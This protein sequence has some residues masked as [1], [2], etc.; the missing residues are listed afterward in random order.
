MIDELGS[1]SKN[2]IDKRFCTYFII[3]IIKLCGS[4]EATLWKRLE[5]LSTDYCYIIKLEISYQIK[6]VLGILFQ[7]GKQLTVEK[8]L[9]GYLKHS[10]TAIVSNTIFTIC[11]HWSLFDDVASEIE[12]AVAVI[13]ERED[14]MEF[15]VIE[16][17]LAALSVEELNL[18]ENKLVEVL[19][20]VIR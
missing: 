13:L 4:T 18:D 5:I 10:L 19:D 3:G 9:K 14:M 16:A 2:N 17:Y 7:E 1:F 12:T 15:Q 6:F 11:S 8:I 20:E